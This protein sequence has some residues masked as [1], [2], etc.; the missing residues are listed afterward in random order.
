MTTATKIEYPIRIK[1]SARTIDELREAEYGRYEDAL[2]A[3][4]RG[5]EDAPKITTTEICDRFRTVLEIRS[6]EELVEVWWSLCSGTAAIHMYRAICTLAD[7]LLPFVEAED[8][9]GRYRYPDG[10]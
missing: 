6:R 9:F 8:A 1:S 7:K 3:R 5:E 4:E 2:G 10:M